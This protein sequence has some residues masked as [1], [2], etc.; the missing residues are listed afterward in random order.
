[1]FSSSWVRYVLVALAGLT[2]A[3]AGF[4]LFRTPLQRQVSQQIAAGTAQNSFGRSKL[5]LLLLGY[6]DDEA[7]TDTVVLAHLDVDRQTATLVSIPRDTWVPVPGAGMQKINAAYAYGGAKST[8]KVVSALLGGI[9]IDATI[10]LQP[11]GASQ[12]VDAI[13]GLNVDVDESMDYDDNNG[14]LHIHLKKGEQY[15]T[16][17]QVVGYIRFRHDATGDFGRVKRQQQILKNMMDQLSQPQNWAKLPRIMQFARKDMSTSLSDQQLLALLEIYRNV[18]DDNVRTFTLPSKVGWVGDA[19]VVFADRRWAKL[20]GDLLFRGVDPPQDEVL[21]ANASGNADVDKT[22]IGALRGAGWNVPTF[23]DQPV[24]STSYVVGE[25]P[26]AQLL[27]KTFAA[28]LRAGKKT[29]LVLGSDLA[30]DT[31]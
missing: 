21:V 13:G 20:V 17:S 4:L 27:S 22:V 16:G 12:I 1:M 28:G 5:N 11:E 24:R 30:P 3:A 19:S 25:T 29:T 31:E 26:A 10:A 23:V 14:A 6:Q 8:A 2:A 18:P 15:L 9:P 7:T